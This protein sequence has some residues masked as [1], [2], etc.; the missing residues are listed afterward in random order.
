[1]EDLVVIAL[2][3][4]PI[5]VIIILFAIFAPYVA[6]MMFFI[7]N[8]AQDVE[9]IG[10]KSN[11]LIE[12]LYNYA[13]GR[14][15]DIQASLP[16]N[17]YQHIALIF[18]SVVLALVFVFRQSWCLAT[19]LHQS[20]STPYTNVHKTSEEVAPIPCANN[21]IRIRNGSELLVNI[22]TTK[23]TIIIIPLVPVFLYEP[24]APHVYHEVQVVLMA[25]IELRCRP[26]K[27]LAPSKAVIL[28]EEDIIS[29]HFEH[30]DHPLP[31][32]HKND[33][34]VHHIV[35]MKAVSDAE[36][37]TPTLDETRS[38]S[39]DEVRSRSSSASSS[40]STDESKSS[41]YSTPTTPTSPKSVPLENV[42]PAVEVEGDDGWTWAKDES[43]NKFLCEILQEMVSQ[44][45]FSHPHA[46]RQSPD[47]ALP[48]DDTPLDVDIE[49]DD[50]LPTSFSDDD[51]YTS[52]LPAHASDSH[53]WT[54]VLPLE[55]KSTENTT[56]AT[57]DA[58]PS[59]NADFDVPSAV[60][61]PFPLRVPTSS[62]QET[63]PNTLSPLPLEEGIPVVENN[64]ISDD[65]INKS[66]LLADFASDHS[67]AEPTEAAPF[68]QP[69]DVEVSLEEVIEAYRKERYNAIYSEL[70]KKKLA[71]KKAKKLGSKKKQHKKKH[72]REVDVELEQGE[73]RTI[74]RE[75]ED[76]AEKLVREKFTGELGGS[77][78]DE[79]VD[80]QV[81]EQ[82]NEQAIEQT[83]EQADML[84]D[85]QCEG[86]L[87]DFTPP[88]ALMEE[89]EI[90][91][92]FDDDIY[93]EDLDESAF[94]EFDE[95][96][97]IPTRAGIIDDAIAQNYFSTPTVTDAVYDT[98]A[99][100]EGGAGVNENVGTSSDTPCDV[101]AEVSFDDTTSIGS[102]KDEASGSPCNALV[103]YQDID[104][105][106]KIALAKSQVPMS[107]MDDSDD[108]PDF[109]YD[110][111]DIKDCPLGKGC[112][113]EDD[114]PHINGCPHEDKCPHGDDCPHVDDYPHK[115]C[116]K[117][118][119]R[120]NPN[121]VKLLLEEA[122]SG[123]SVLG[124]HYVWRIVRYLSLDPTM[125][126]QGK[127]REANFTNLVDL[128]D[129][130]NL[131]QEDLSEEDLIAA[132]NTE[133]E[134]QE[135]FEALR[136]SM[137]TDVTDANKP[138]F[139]EVTAMR[140]F[141]GLVLL[142][143]L[144]G[145]HDKARKL[146]AVLDRLKSPGFRSKAWFAAKTIFYRLTKQDNLYF[147][148][149][150]FLKRVRLAED[151][152]LEYDTPYNLD[153]VVITGEGDGR[154]YGTFFQA[155]YSSLHVDACVAEAGENEDKG[156]TQTDNMGWGALNISKDDNIT[157]KRTIGKNTLILQ[158]LK[159]DHTLMQE[160][161]KQKE[162][163]KSEAFQ[164]FGSWLTNRFRKISHATS[165]RF[166]KHCS[167]AKVREEVRKTLPG[168]GTFKCP[169][170]DNYFEWEDYIMAKFSEL[171]EQE[172][173]NMNDLSDALWDESNI[174]EEWQI[175]EALQYENQIAM[176][177]FT[178]VRA[179]PKDFDMHLQVLEDNHDLR[180]KYYKQQKKILSDFE[181]SL[182]KAYDQAM[183][184]A[185]R[186]DRGRWPPAQP[187]RVEFDKLK[188]LQKKQNEQL[189]TLRKIQ[190]T[191]YFSHLKSISAEE[192]RRRSLRCPETR[193]NLWRSQYTDKFLAEDSK[194]FNK[195]VL[196]QFDYLNTWIE[197]AIQQCPPTNPP[198]ASRGFNFASPGQ[199][200][201]LFNFSGSA[202]Q[203]SSPAPFAGLGTTPQPF[204]FTGS[205]NN[206]MLR[207]APNAPSQNGAFNFGSTPQSA[208]TSA[209]WRPKATP[210]SRATP[211][212]SQS[213]TPSDSNNPFAGPSTTS[214]NFSNTEQTFPF[215][216]TNNNNDQGSRS[217][218]T[219]SGKSRFADM[220]AEKS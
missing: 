219:P 62:P 107:I 95:I 207:Q 180:R 67:S 63:S 23:G 212:T 206:E 134:Y 120:Y 104:E 68:P 131:D 90:V 160:V 111:T 73:I 198:P 39:S 72:A 186:R 161:M 13:I 127:A 40:T 45:C 128:E 197:K 92:E 76:A 201:T 153:W 96:S 18:S 1:M 188:N 10:H 144:N 52:P 176:D 199:N 171:S 36:S 214:F 84:T 30:D 125:N 213:G 162:D 57:S 163:V 169:P 175:K 217:G 184:F 21:S 119:Q 71:E 17:G 189:A 139:D 183:N 195:F 77:D 50:E 44:G 174:F 83:D 19:K 126:E 187:Y 15:N 166:A 109:M 108:E 121:H 9:D 33:D 28:Q 58:T 106:I 100:N 205:A 22:I 35:D 218:P 75:A 142:H 41:R 202:T 49:I 167:A 5:P 87:S 3:C 135:I 81:N 170:T 85:E 102:H 154:D 105:M 200:S 203:S 155:W 80:E 66:V 156:V 78:V 157:L 122:L 14:P 132:E 27:P 91:S 59:S 123:K 178:I 26:S 204:A 82:I 54:Y 34:G 60:T 210:K 46:V 37:R 209:D 140:Y 141:D 56:S 168:Y 118:A 138:G 150:D 172:Q 158:G 11:K 94:Q 8:H 137:V 12:R 152:R 31:G 159:H 130:D 124:M 55:V 182:R 48:K 2:A 97:D 38:T 47:V 136:K 113:H 64:F 181:E 147:A 194:K 69:V 114:Y 148:F 6:K 129:E 42:D 211:A 173:G 179:H 20:L 117:A 133:K 116:F 32:T 53:H 43:E 220:W 4:L 177:F 29:E 112:P 185:L 115:I 215:A 7:A 164:A 88:A 103:I 79:Q 93:D 24:I 165:H 89:D 74:S 143:K 149:L 99:D 25:A 101:A 146:Q 193:I 208:S 190:N 191:E 16:R 98:V 61:I 216:S 192:E 70:R 51:D 86:T 196:Q 110:Y 145:R 151:Y 65:N